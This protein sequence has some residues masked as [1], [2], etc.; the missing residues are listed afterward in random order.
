M[1]RKS[2]GEASS[3]RGRTDT[4]H[5]R[6]RK[7]SCLTKARSFMTYSWNQKGLLTASLTASS[8]HMD[9]VDSV[10]GMPNA[11]A[12]RAPSISPSGQLLPARPV[13]AMATGMDT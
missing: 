8:G 10:N 12:A 6:A 2:N 7:M 1:L 4:L 3:A 9:M 5:A 11:S 13:G